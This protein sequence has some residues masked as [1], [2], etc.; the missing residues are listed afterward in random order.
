MNP[1][2]VLN[3]L[4]EELDA[5]TAFC[6]HEGVGVEITSFAFPSSLENGLQARIARHAEA[7]DG[8][9]RV[10]F[11]GPFLDLYVTSP[12]PAIVEVCRRRHR[13]ALR[14][15]GEIGATLYVAHLNALPH[16]RTTSYRDRFV[17]AAAEF[18][19]PFADEAGERG[20]TIV[21]ENMWEDG[22][23]LQRRVVEEAA[24]PHLKASFDNGHALVFSDV[25]AP[26]WIETLGDHLAHCHVHDNDGTY[27]RH[28]PIGDGGENWPAFWAALEA[29]A[30]QA[31]VVL[32]CDRLAANQ[33]SLERV[34]RDE[35]GVV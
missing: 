16:I 32:E 28:W 17:R 30:P 9:A 3:V 25:S 5:A 1:P 26:T 6:R 34:R 4:E 35:P 7:T 8:L 21:L 27:D 23:E 20:I 14:A 2:L 22:P 11:H 31:V 15:A 33:R 18:W 29:F 19:L 13:A 24:H 10:T 12:D